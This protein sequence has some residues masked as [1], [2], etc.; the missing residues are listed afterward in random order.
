MSLLMVY[1]IIFLLAGCYGLSLCAKVR[2][3][4]KLED[5]KILMPRRVKLEEC[6]DAEAFIKRI[7]P[8]MAAFGAAIV[9]NGAAGIVE[10]MHLG[11][12]HE[13]HMVTLVICLA[14]AI[15]FFQFQHKA[16]KEFWDLDDEE[17]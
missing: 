2:M 14:A 8:W 13:V 5:I 7:W 16:V 6:L 10:D 9:L 17:D 15:T 1:D 11:L 12:P 4:G 3:S